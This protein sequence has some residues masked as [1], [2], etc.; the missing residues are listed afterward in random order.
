VTNDGPELRDARRKADAFWAAARDW[1]T[2]ALADVAARSFDVAVTGDRED[3]R[4]EAH[5]DAR[6]VVVFRG[7]D[8]ARSTIRGT[9]IRQMTLRQAGGVGRREYDR[10]LAGRGDYYVTAWFAVD[11]VVELE[12]AVIVD[13]AALRNVLAPVRRRMEHG[14]MSN[15]PFVGY[16]ASALI[17]HGLTVAA[18]PDA[19]Y[20]DR[21]V[22]GREIEGQ[23]SLLL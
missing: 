3:I 23:G 19:G 18:Y 1:T 9:P 15:V 4:F 22:P 14:G 21:F 13:L 11:P 12:S 6:A 2:A 20:F 16:D 17:A 8:A 7:R 10:V 5:G